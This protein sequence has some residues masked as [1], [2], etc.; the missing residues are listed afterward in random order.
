MFFRLFKAIALAL[1]LGLSMSCFAAELGDGDAL[2]RETSV[3]VL[4]AKT[5]D[6]LY[7]T[8]DLWIEKRHPGARVVVHTFEYVADG[9]ALLI[10][11]TALSDGSFRLFYFETPGLPGQF[12]HE[13]TR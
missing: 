13:A 5:E 11:R 7:G 12:A 9:R 8:L 3:K 10:L 4:S 1:S 2:T 6:D